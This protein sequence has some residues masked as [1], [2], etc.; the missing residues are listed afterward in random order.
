MPCEG[1]RTNEKLNRLDGK[2]GRMDFSDIIDNRAEGEN[3]LACAKLVELRMLR[4]FDR[5]CKEHGLRYSLAYGTLLGAIRHRGFI[6]WDDDIDV[7]M[8]L[9]DYR[10]FVRLS[11]RDLPHDMILVKPGTTYSRVSFAKIFDLKS[12]Y[13]DKGA[14]YQDIDAPRGIFIDIFPLA[15]YGCSKCNRF[16]TKLNWH[17]NR[18][19]GKVGLVTLRNLVRRWLW[20]TVKYLFIYPLD[21]MTRRRNGDW[22]GVPQFLGGDFSLFPSHCFSKLTR[23]TFEGFDFMAP[24]DWHEYLS[25]AYGDYMQL[26]PRERQFTHATV[27]VP[28]LG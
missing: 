10:K 27:I 15:R 8:P 18:L 6:P 22:L 25:A 23:V 14:R 24:S 17:A 2:G 26:P 3:P 21:R 9:E 7:H 20:L 5:I 19:T 28:D 13:L 12:F 16:L 11:F 1:G 4:V